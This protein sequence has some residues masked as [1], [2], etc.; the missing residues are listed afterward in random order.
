[1]ERG[2]PYALLPS[3]RSPVLAGPS[4]SYLLSPSRHPGVPVRLTRLALSRRACLCAGVLRLRASLQDKPQRVFPAFPVPPLRH[5][6]GWVCCGAPPPTPPEAGQTHE[7]RPP[8]EAWGIPQTVTRLKTPKISPEN[9]SGSMNRMKILSAKIAP[10]DPPRVSEPSPDHVT[11]TPRT[12]KT[13]KTRTN[14]LCV[15]SDTVTRKGD[16]PARAGE[17]GRGEDPGLRLRRPHFT[18]AAHGSG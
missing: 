17:G 16:S 11:S 4:S 9:F 18:R 8:G 14:C 10:L 1:M 2:S 3:P 15:T 7:R 6:S 5:R 13:P 12:R